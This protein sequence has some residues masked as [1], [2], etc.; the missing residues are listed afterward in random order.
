[1]P[2]LDRFAQ[3]L[4]DPQEHQP[5]PISECENLECSKPI[6]AGQKIWKHGADHYCSLRCLAESIGA[7]DVTAL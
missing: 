2:S 1:M 5:E 7:S 3:G 6:Y 4:P